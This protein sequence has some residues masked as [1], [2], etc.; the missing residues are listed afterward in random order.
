[1]IVG[2]ILAAG[3]SR[4]MGQDKLALPWRDSTVLQ[5][6]LERWLAVPEIDH[7]IL[8]RRPPKSEAPDVPMVGNH[9]AM[10]R[11]RI[12]LNP[13]ADEGMGRSISVGMAAVPPGTQAVLVGLADMPDVQS[14]TISS[15]VDLWRF[16][17]PRQI[18]SPVHASR[19]GHPVLFGAE[20][21]DALKA[22]TGDIGARKLLASH[23]ELQAMLL[24][25]DPGVLRDIDTPEDVKSA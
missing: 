15:L 20:H 4:R 3:A 8:V 24:T 5:C 19:R 13:W 7:L 1:M 23:P 9:E 14:A 25:Q 12:V 22:L 2:I 18:V 16:W 6:T 11:V 17:A 21:F 10:A